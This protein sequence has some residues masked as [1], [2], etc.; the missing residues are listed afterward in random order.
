MEHESRVN[1]I[2]KKKIVNQVFNIYFYTS[3]IT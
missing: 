1:N 3:I 2:M